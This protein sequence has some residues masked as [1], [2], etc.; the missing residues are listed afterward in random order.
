MKFSHTERRTL[1][2]SQDI[3]FHARSCD[4]VFCSCLRC[5][6]FSSF[7][8]Q[9]IAFN[10]P[11]YQDM[12]P[13]SRATQ[14]FL[15]HNASPT[16]ESRKRSRNEQERTEDRRESSSSS[17]HK[18]PSRKE[19]R[20]R[21]KS[22]SSNRSGSPDSTPSWAKKLLEA[23]QKSEERLQHLEKELKSRPATER[24]REKSPQPD[25][26]YK[27]NKIQYEL[28][29]KVLD[30]IDAAASASDETGRNQALEEG[31]K[32][33]KERN[34]HIQLAEKYGW[35]AVDCYVQEPLACDSDDEKRIKRAIKE[36]KVLKAESKKPSKPRA[37]LFGRSQQSF[38]AN[39]NSPGARRVVLPAS[40]QK[41][42]SSQ[43]D[44]CFR[45]G[46]AGHFAKN[47]RAP[48]PTATTGKTY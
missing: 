15:A 22:K 12:P 16:R 31:R 34:K 20:S 45:C 4:S 9:K 30:Q 43:S 48:I 5:N 36:S 18:S 40:R 21:S 28:N 24:S 39:P 10:S 37:Q 44:G 42:E 46:R 25:F 17:R 47:C 13:K 19:R 6:S 35:E 3:S 33:L 23:H 2:P 41:F 11:S 1:G 29:M 27:R 38:T 32:L 8:T 14:R 7:I 26:K